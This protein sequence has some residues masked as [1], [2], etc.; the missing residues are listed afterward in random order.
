[1]E[2][3]EDKLD[4]R[5]KDEGPTLFFEVGEGVAKLKLTFIEGVGGVAQLELDVAQLDLGA[6][7]SALGATQL[8]LGVAQ[9]QIGVAQLQLG[10]AQL[11]L[12][13]ALS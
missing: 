2:E 7:Q 6:A 12:G 9:L 8:K 13:A 1:M 3:Y 5:L 4:G 11:Q 10:V